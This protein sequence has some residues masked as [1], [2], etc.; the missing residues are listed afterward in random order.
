MN[1]RIIVT[2]QDVNEVSND[3]REVEIQP[4]FNKNTSFTD[5]STNLE[6]L[7]LDVQRNV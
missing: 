1:G 5:L 2:I 3:G 7:V 4:I 6:T